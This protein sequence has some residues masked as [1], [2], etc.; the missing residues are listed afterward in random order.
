MTTK[1]QALIISAL[2][3]LFAALPASAAMIFEN[4][5]IKYELLNGPSMY[6]G[7]PTLIGTS[8][9]FTFDEDYRAEQSG[10]NPPDNVFETLNF[11]V[12]ILN[13]ALILGGV[14]VNEGGDWKIT[15]GTS[16]SYDLGTVVTE[17]S[18]PNAGMPQQENSGNT[19]GAILPSAT[20]WTASTS[21]ELSGE[22]TMFLLSVENN[23][24]ANSAGMLNNAWI[25]KKFISITTVTTPVPVPAAVWM[26]GSV[27]ATLGL[28]RRKEQAKA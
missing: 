6:G 22:G 15:G 1:L 8:L 13:E 21:H 23:L 25:D 7:N 26:F 2:I 4:E 19:E 16:V 27:L 20:A 9:V 14:N 24:S 5:D 28:F 18:G 3:L 10:N 11:K 12:T 17:F